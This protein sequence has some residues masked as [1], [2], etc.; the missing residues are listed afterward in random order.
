MNKPQSP[1]QGIMQTSEYDSVKTYRVACS[2]GQ[3]EHSHD[4]WIGSESDINTVSV[5]VYTKVFS[6]KGRW[7]MIWQL[8]TR[9]H[10]ELEASILMNKQ[11]AIN[12]ASTL[13]RA[14]KDL[15]KE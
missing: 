14:I 6:H 5:T 7:R 9:G 13:Q 8:L 4:V 12:Y 11:Q 1:A 10:I 3:Q 2:C 15:S